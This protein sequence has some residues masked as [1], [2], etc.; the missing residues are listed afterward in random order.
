MSKKH[1]CNFRINRCNRWTEND[2]CPKHSP[3]CNPPKQ[4]RL[5]TPTLITLESCGIN[6]AKSYK[7]WCLKNHPDKV[8]PKDRV[9][10]TSN[11]Q[12]ISVLFADLNGD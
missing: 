6:D 8:L 2:M 4:N 3:K 11:F 12:K 7:Q 5:C 9:K 10:A 1:L